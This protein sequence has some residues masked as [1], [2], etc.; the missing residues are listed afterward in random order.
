MLSTLLRR[1]FAELYS[2]HPGTSLRLSAAIFT[3]IIHDRIV[4]SWKARDSQDRDNWEQLAV[5]LL[6]GVQDHVEAHD[7]D[8]VKVMVAKA[9]YSILCNAFFSVSFPIPLTSYSVP[10]RVSVYSILSMTAD[11]C[12]E[13]KSKLRDGEILGGAM[14]GRIITLTNG[15]DHPRHV[16]DHLNLVVV[17]YLALEQLLLLLAYLLPPTESRVT[18]HAERLGFLRD[19]FGDTTQRGKELIELLKFVI[20]PDWEITSDKIVDILARDI[21][22]TQPFVMKRFVL[23]GLSN[24][25]LSPAL[26][27][28]LDKTSIL[29]NCEDEEDGKIEGMHV[30]YD[31]MRY[32]D[33]SSSGSVTAELL[34]PPLCHQPLQIVSSEAAILMTIVLSLPDVGRF[35]KTLR[36]RGMTSRVQFNGGPIP[37]AAERTSVNISPTR[38]EFEGSQS[39]AS[40]QSKVK[41]VEEG[42]RLY[43]LFPFAAT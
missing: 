18:G 14:L 34:S 4:P 29:F 28:Y 21:S 23:S 17:D 12:I 22:V 26:R 11:G 42:G 5:V 37:K 36:I 6:A 15:R 30:P 33:I 38:L 20:S 1:P 40:Y 39:V 2:T 16:A 9:F 27:F 31:S 7:E 13:N 25:R 35:V 10:L 3:T 24:L 19:C 41:V 32:V 8:R 43:N